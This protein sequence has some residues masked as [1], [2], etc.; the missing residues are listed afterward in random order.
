[1]AVKKI[2]LHNQTTMDTV[3][4]EIRIMQ[5]LKHCPGVICLEDAFCDEQQNV[6]L[7]MELAQCSLMDLLLKRNRAV[8]E[9][10]ARD[11]FVQIART[12]FALHR[13]NIVHRDIKLDNIYIVQS[14][15][16]STYKSFS[17]FLF[18]LAPSI[19]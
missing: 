18:S 17:V 19:S 10:D 2:L 16:Q 3:K 15:S 14:N 1:V 5:Q 13:Q 6:F 7:V 11:L 8:Y 12:V 4:N 9:D